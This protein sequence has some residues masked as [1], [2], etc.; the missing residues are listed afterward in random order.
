MVQG[1]PPRFGAGAWKLNITL[2]VSSDIYL[3]TVLVPSKEKNHRV[4]GGRG[5]QWIGQ[6]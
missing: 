5:C 3:Q 2:G 4:G 1:G 6:L